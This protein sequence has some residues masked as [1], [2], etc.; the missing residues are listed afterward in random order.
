MYDTSAAI[1]YAADPA[2]QGYSRYGYCG[3]NPVIMVDPTGRE[4][5]S[6]SDANEMAIN[7]HQWQEAEETTAE[8]QAQVHEDRMETSSG[9]RATYKAMASVG[10][11]KLQTGE[12]ASE[13]ANRLGKAADDLA[14][15]LAEVNRKAA[16][17]G[18]FLLACNWGDANDIGT[19]EVLLLGP[20]KWVKQA[21]GQCYKACLAMTG[22]SSTLQWTI[23][24]E[25]DGDKSLTKTPDYNDGIELLNEQL[26][27]GS[28][29][30]VGVND[31]FGT[32]YNE[33]HTT[34]HFITIVGFGID[35]S[36]QRY[37]R[38]Y[39]PGSKNQEE[40]TLPT[41]CLYYNSSSGLWSGY[42]PKGSQKYEL[43]MVRYR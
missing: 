14:E 17:S 6:A 34:D 21:S 13:W 15:Q 41:N 9:Y 37:Y 40:G 1:F 19:G 26:F 18:N 4:S 38:F 8:F 39:D 2:N 12:I 20:D 7:L 3:G 5:T 10:L 23:V 43:T 16:R 28:P 33:D 29:V 36:G 42:S 27:N 25:D 35:N 30:I 22:Y 31:R 32:T 24:Y 11:G